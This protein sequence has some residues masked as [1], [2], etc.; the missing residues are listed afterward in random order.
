[1]IRIN[2][3]SECSGCT[4][5]ASI[6]PRDAISMIPDKL[7]FL[8]PEVDN[9]KCIDCGICESVCSFNDNY[10]RTLNLPSPIAYGARHINLN[11]VFT[12]QSGAAF[13]AISDHVLNQGGVVYGVK[14]ENHFHVVHKR[15]LTKRERDEFKGSKYVQSDLSGVFN[16]IKED[17]SNGLLVLF[18]GT[19]CQT[20]GLHSFIGKKYRKNLILVDVVCHG[21]TGPFV[22]RD[23][24]SLLEKK[25]GDSIC[26]FRFGDKERFG[27]SHRHESFSFAKNCDIAKWNKKT[28]YTPLLF[29][30]SCNK[31][32]FCNTARPSDITIGDFWGYQKV[33]TTI[34]NDDK[35]L[36]LVLVNTEKGVRLWENA[37]KDMV[38]FPVNVEDCIQANLQAPTE[39]HPKRK[40]FEIDYI[41]KGFSYAWA[42]NYNRLS[43]SQRLVRYIKRNLPIFF[44]KK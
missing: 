27:W 14:F 4:A 31:C 43:F 26:E 15:A 18:T 2:N 44:N 9:T 24:I 20:A 8:Y 30:D 42:R 36:S 41:K 11:E 12:S 38:T 19:P 25:Q 33:N 39:V 23:Y 17:L 1:M 35:G 34:N 7:G 32:H 40:Q 3:K 10:D 28:E 22:W 5:C 6:C 13:I 21:V 29:R 37:R 16:L